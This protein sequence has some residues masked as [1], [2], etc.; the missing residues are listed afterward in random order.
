MISFVQHLST[1]HASVLTNPFV[2]PVE[3]FDRML[4]PIKTIS[5]F[6]DLHDFKCENL[7]A[8]LKQEYGSN[9]ITSRLP[10]YHYGPN[11][12]VGPGKFPMHGLSFPSSSQLTTTMDCQEDDII[13]PSTESLVVMRIP[14]ELEGRFKILSSTGKTASLLVDDDCKVF[15]SDA[16]SNI[17]YKSSIPVPMFADLDQHLD[18]YS[19]HAARVVGCGKVPLSGVKFNIHK[20]DDQFLVF[21]R[22]GH[23]GEL[24]SYAV[25]IGTIPYTS[26]QLSNLG[27][28][29]N[30]LSSLSSGLGYPE[31]GSKTSSTGYAVY[32][33]DSQLAERF[34]QQLKKRNR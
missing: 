2:F 18:F 21:Q 28:M 20:G 24:E 8:S 25:W 31:F 30:T 9:S 34:Y 22:Y 10:V 33:E 32:I 13:E 3:G 27:S 23:R 16:D 4:Y 14:C 17:R 7:A 26:S 5:D 15:G 6:F 1:L 19:I 29:G 12:P 11:S